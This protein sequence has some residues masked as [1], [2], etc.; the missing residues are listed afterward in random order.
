MAA[1]SGSFVVSRGSLVPPLSAPF[2]RSLVGS[3][4]SAGA[5]R[6]RVRRSA[7]SFSGFVVVAGFGSSAAAAAFASAWAGGCGL[8]LAVRAFAGGMWGVSVPVA[9]LQSCRRG[10][11]PVLP[12]PQWVRV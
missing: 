3:A 11:P 7:R 2:W 8:P 12:R 5:L 4:L 10:V 9:P 1:S 6:W